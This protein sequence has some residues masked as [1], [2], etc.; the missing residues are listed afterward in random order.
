[1]TK[2]QIISGLTKAFYKTK[3]QVIKHSPQILMAGGTIGVI[4]SCVLACRATLKASEI[5]KEAKQGVEDIHTV[6]TTPELNA[7]YEAK[8]GEA[9][10]EE[11]AKKELAATYVQAGLKLAKTYA[12][13]VVLG[14]ASLGCILGSHRISTKRNMAL[15]A[16]YATI[17]RGFKDYRGRVVERFGEELDKEL[18][19][20]IKTKE[21]EET[22]TD[23]NGETKTVKTTV[24]TIEPTQ[25]SGYAKCFDETC[26]GWTRNAEENYFFLM[27]QQNWANEKL[28][29]EGYLFLNDVYK[30]L[31]FPPTAAG[32]QVGWIYDEKNPIGD[33]FVD[34][35]I[36]NLHDKEKRM[37][38][39]G[40]EKSIWLDFN[41]DGYLL[42]LMP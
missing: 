35:G 21:I 16:A 11:A 41:V 36:H 27:A 17:D 12:P 29:S 5:V 33:N 2:V 38:V 13:A 18:R 19:Y 1:M 26:T 39:N 23:E 9:F 22:V 34:F 32:Q 4:G 24:K 31:G 40:Y 15:A 30:A 6:L 37:F 10:T 42:D 3:F 25:Y 8:N 7:A 14:A 20:N 28:K